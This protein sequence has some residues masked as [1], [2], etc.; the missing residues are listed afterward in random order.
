VAFGASDPLDLMRDGEPSAL[1]WIFGK[2][3]FLVDRAVAILKQ[4]VLDPR[5]RDFNYDLF[6]GK[7]AGAQKILGASRTLP[8]MA[9]RRLVIVRDAES[10]DAKQLDALTP[11]VADP[12][13]ETCLVFVAEKVDSRLKFFNGFKKKGVLVKCDPLADRQ[14]PGFVRA[15]GAQR[16]LKFEPGAAEMIADEVGADLGQ[17]VDAVERI[18]LYLGERKLVSAA[19][20]EAVVATTRQRSVFELADAIGA[21]E[22]ARALQALGSLLA[23]R[24]PALKILALIGRLARQLLVTRELLDRRAGRGEIME[25]LGVPPFVVDKLEAQAKRFDP[26]GLRRMHAAIYRA[27][28]TLKSSKLQDDRVMELLVLELARKRPAARAR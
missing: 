20:V 25:R 17:I 22:P 19:D 21:G 16:K 5:T 6:Y 9:K 4:R 10:L 26:A 13:P 23:A 24:E 1:Y 3:R 27:D 12:A 8:M 15:E 7:E 28:R 11:Y 14:V 2:E 18:E